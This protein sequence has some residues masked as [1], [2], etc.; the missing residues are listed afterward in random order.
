MVDDPDEVFE[1]AADRCGRCAESLDGAVETARVRRQVVDVEPP[2]PPKVTEYQLVSR[3][4]GGCGQVNDPTATDVP[5]PVDPSSD[6]AR[7]GASA[8][9]EPGAPEPAAAT[10]LTT[11]PVSESGYA[12]TETGLVPDPVLALALRPGSPVRIGPQTTALAALLTCGHYLPIGRATSVLDALAGIRVSTGSTAGVRGG[13][14]PC[15]RA[16]SCHTCK[17]CYPRPGCYTP[18][19][20]PGGP[21]GRWRM[22]TWPAPSI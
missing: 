9:P 8:P 11:K 13:L 1:V 19:R 2:P 21:P 18:M 16:P 10:E 12:P 15:W 3:R 14:R 4:C 6:V 5:R 22:C 7:R 20:P 17:P